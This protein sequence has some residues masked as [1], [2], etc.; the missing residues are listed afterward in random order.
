MRLFYAC[1]VDN[2]DYVGHVVE[3]IGPQQVSLALDY[4]VDIR[5]IFRPVAATGWARA[6]LPICRRSAAPVLACSPLV[7]VDEQRRRALQV[8][9]QHLHKFRRMHT[10]DHP[11]IERR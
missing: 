1:H 8:A 11:V 7:L 6:V 2:V 10:I 9:A 3:L 4:A 5:H